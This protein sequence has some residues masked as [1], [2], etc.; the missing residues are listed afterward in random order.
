MFVYFFMSMFC[1][2][3]SDLSGR[4][5][6]ACDDGA[7]ACVSPPQSNAVA[8]HLQAPMRHG[9]IGRSSSA[10]VEGPCVDRSIDPTSGRRLPTRHSNGLQALADDGA[11]IDPTPAWCIEYPTRP[12]ID[13]STPHNH[14]TQDDAAVGTASPGRDGAPAPAGG[15]RRR[16]WLQ[17]GRRGHR[18]PLQLLRHA[19]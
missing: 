4:R 2:S 3:S 12:L 18:G 7:R 13:R 16:L 14:A 15:A 9:W 11:W 8:C 17:G 1:S 5:G 19:Q 6:R 10:R